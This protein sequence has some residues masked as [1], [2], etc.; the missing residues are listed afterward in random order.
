MVIINYSV[1]LKGVIAHDAWGPIMNRYRI[2]L[3]QTLAE[4]GQRMIR[5]YLPT[6][7]MYLG[8]N[9]GDPRNNP[10]PPDA[11]RL[12]ESVV[13]DFVSEGYYLVKTDEVI[14]GPWIEGVAVGNTFIWPGRIRRGLSP[15]FPGY[16][17]FRHATQVLN[18][19]AFE[20]AERE[21]PYYIEQLET[22]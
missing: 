17:A 14:V 6:Q 13:T 19:V 18:D 5:A 11:G 1:D 7:Y 4:R 21:L 8:N 15:R 22:Y 10:I 16:H 3:E 12:Q 20:V 2:H 9:G